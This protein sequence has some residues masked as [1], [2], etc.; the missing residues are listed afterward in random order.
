MSKT[1]HA[2]IKEQ[3]RQEDYSTA[4]DECTITLRDSPT[5]TAMIPWLLVA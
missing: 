3:M 2:F 1:G 4:G 5:A